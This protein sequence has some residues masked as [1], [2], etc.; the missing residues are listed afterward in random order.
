[1]EA[2]EMKAR[3]RR[4]SPRDPDAI[5]EGGEIELP[6]IVSHVEGEPTP[7]DEEFNF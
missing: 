5:Y 2:S 1:M 3:R 7:W 4:A 6:F